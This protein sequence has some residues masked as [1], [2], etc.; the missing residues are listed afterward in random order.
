VKHIPYNAFSLTTIE[1]KEYHDMTQHETRLTPQQHAQRI[2]ATLQGAQQECHNNSAQVNDPRAQALFETLAE[3]L[4]GAIKA[5]NDYQQG[6]EAAWKSTSQQE[7]SKA[8]PRH[9]QPGYARES[10]PSMTEFAVDVDASEPPPA[11]YK[12]IP[13]HNELHE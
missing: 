3:V 9:P 10:A 7:Q 13:G 4:G 5:L 11:I 6:N 1:E 2:A 12:E 8:A